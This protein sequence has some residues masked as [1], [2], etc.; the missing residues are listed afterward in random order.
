[1]TV[2]EDR[3]GFVVQAS[4]PQNTQ[5]LAVGA[6]SV[7]SQPFAVNQDR[8]SRASD[9][10][11]QPSTLN[12]TRHIRIVCTVSAWVSFGTNPAPVAVRQG[13]SSM[14][15]PAGL[16]EYFWVVAGESVAV[17]Q[18]TTGGFCYI[19]ELTN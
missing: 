15:M 11:P 1:M 10:N 4:R 5:V 8:P 9:G 18:D 14:Y 17:I 13:T 16:P 12:N 3:F 19:T 7:L 2:R 6:A